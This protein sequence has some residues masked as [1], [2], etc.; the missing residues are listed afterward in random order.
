[1]GQG[2]RPETR[3]RGGDR[4]A[5]EAISQLLSLKDWKESL[6]NWERQQTNI[7]ADE[8][9]RGG[10]LPCSQAQSGRGP[11]PGCSPPPPGQGWRWEAS[12][13]GNSKHCP[14]GLRGE[15]LPARRTPLLEQHWD[16]VG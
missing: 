16:L 15:P 11:P 7:P 8:I 2:V 12:A 13:T 14:E 4:Q 5:S 6:Q 1:M 10:S 3:G 9:T